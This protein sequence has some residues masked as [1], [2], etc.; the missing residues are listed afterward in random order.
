MV[1]NP[2]VAQGHIRLSGPLA[3]FGESCNK[4]LTSVGPQ[5]GPQKRSG[6][7]PCGM[8]F[9]PDPLV[10]GTAWHGNKRAIA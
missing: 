5:N 10:R 6:F 3:N 8:P 1:L 4:G 9:R 2:E 7:S